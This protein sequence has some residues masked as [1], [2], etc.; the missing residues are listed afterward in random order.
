[1][2]RTKFATLCCTAL[3]LTFCALLGCGVSVDPVEAVAR[4]NSN[5][6]QRVANL[7]LA[8]QAERDWIG[9]P[10]EATFKDFIRGYSAEKL[11]RIGVDPNKIDELFVSE[12][13]GQPFKIRYSI[14]GSMMGSSEPVV[15]EAAGA[16]GK[17]MVAFLNMEQREV[18]D[19]EYN[20]L[21]SGTTPTEERRRRSP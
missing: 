21:W 7:Y 11:N 1:V 9:P 10:D 19:A 14:V 16:G 5:N 13:D 6:L 15:F 17:R 12:R 4:A 3:V 20:H 2:L 8:Y 18:D